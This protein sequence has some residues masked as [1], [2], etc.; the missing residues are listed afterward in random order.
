MRNYSLRY[1]DKISCK[2]DIKCQ[3][4]YSVALV[5][6]NV[7]TSSPYLN[8]PWILFSDVSHIWD[9]RVD[10]GTNLFGSGATNEVLAQFVQTDARSI[11]DALSPTTGCA[12]LNAGNQMPS[13]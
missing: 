12:A 11:C 2:T 6:A 8:A 3:V 4:T 5:S 10:F 9:S 7:I 13:G 1:F